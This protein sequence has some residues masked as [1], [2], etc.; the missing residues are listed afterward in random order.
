VILKGILLN[1]VVQNEGHK[2]V[3]QL[4]T[5]GTHPQGN[6]MT[7][8][9]KK[10]PQTSIRQDHLRNKPLL[11][12]LISIK[13]SHLSKLKMFLD[14]K[15]KS[16]QLDTKMIKITITRIFKEIVM[17]RTNINKKN[18]TNVKGKDLPNNR[19]ITLKYSTVRTHTTRMSQIK[20]TKI[21]KTTTNLLRKNTSQLKDQKAKER[22]VNAELKRTNQAEIMRMSPKVIKIR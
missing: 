3:N 2:T 9:I 5:E 19:K 15:S 1:I 11:T 21:T 8:K 22:A 10:K 17:T 13:R 16:H 14:P 20:S 12:Q 7:L 6:K 4:K 18:N